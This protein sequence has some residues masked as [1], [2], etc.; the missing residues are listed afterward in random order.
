M[1]LQVEEQAMQWGRKMPTACE[2]TRLSAGFHYPATQE[3]ASQDGKTRCCNSL[4][5]EAQAH[6]K[7]IVVGLIAD[8][9]PGFGNFVV[10]EHHETVAHVHG[11]ILI[12]V[13]GHARTHV[14]GEVGE[15][16]A[17]AGIVKSR[18]H[19]I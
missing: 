1:G 6:Q 13:V 2:K 7:L 11:E 12:D 14:P 17:G 19:L 15:V 16:V 10:S 8:L 9:C 5:S 4:K 18:R 3:N